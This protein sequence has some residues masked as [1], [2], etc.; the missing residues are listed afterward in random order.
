MVNSPRMPQVYICTAPCQGRPP[1]EGT[2]THM[3]READTANNVSFFFPSKSPAM[4]SSKHKLEA[5][6]LNL[7][8]CLVGGRP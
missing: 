6:L 2:E 8:V 1:T 3:K 4:Y 5:S 7:A